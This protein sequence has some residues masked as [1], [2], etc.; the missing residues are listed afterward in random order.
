M[1]E[2]SNV[3]WVLKMAWGQRET[4]SSARVCVCVGGVFLKQRGR[5][6]E[7]P[8][9][10]VK[11]FCKLLRGEAS[12]VVHT[13]EISNLLDTFCVYNESGK[14]LADFVVKTPVWLFR[15]NVG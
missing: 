14:F 15:W 10:Q 13:A 4:V 12:L 11:G 7:K 9:K 5:E 2:N 6:R 8:F 1:N 3:K